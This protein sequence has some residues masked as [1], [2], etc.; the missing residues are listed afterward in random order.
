M[1]AKYP[2]CCRDG[3]MNSSGYERHFLIPSF[4]RDNQISRLPAALGALHN[5]EFMDFARNSVDLYSDDMY[6]A[7]MQLGSRSALRYAPWVCLYMCVCACVRVRMRMRMRMC[8]RV[9]V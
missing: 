1:G 2:H 9:Y 4:H 8:V 7:N 5:L 6:A 3:S